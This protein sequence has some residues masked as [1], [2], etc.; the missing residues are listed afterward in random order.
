MAE[1]N[2]LAIVDVTAYIENNIG[3]FHQNRLQSIRKLKLG[4]ILKR[5]NPYLFKAK[6]VLLA[7]DLVKILLDAYLSSQEEAIFGRF[8]EGLAIYINGAVFSGKKSGAEGVDL[9]FEKDGIWYIVA[10]KSGPNWGNSSQIRKMKDDF[11]RTKRIL[12]TTDAPNN[13]VAV[14]GCAYGKETKPDKGE[15]YKYCGQAFWEFISGDPDLYTKLIKPLGHKAKE[16]N[17][18]FAEEYAGVVNRFTAEFQK[19]FCADDG[20]IDWECLVRFNSS[21]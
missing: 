13:I 3:T 14:N 9:E 7:Q 5:K 12:R 19:D 18:E 16:K 21:K 10:I 4:N 2:A 17:H 1:I 8:L 6:N 15:Y 20:K 11:T